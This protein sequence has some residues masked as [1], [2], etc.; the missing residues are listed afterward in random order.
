MATRVAFDFSK[1][2]RFL[3]S[4]LSL[5]VVMACRVSE[6]TE[7]DMMLILQV[8]GRCLKCARVAE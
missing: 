6:K 3:E 7:D 4:S 5:V 1:M 2:E 8:G